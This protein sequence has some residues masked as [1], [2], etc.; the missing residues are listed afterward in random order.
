MSLIL[1]LGQYYGSILN[2]RQTSAMTL[3]EVSYS[4][5]LSTPKHCHQRA[6]IVISL[7]GLSTQLYDNKP[8]TC[9]A[10]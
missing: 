10:T 1:D 7:E 8:T 2:A 6:L 9:K 3:S 4:S 5:G